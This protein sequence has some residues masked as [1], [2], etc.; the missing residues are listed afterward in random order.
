VTEKIE[1]EEFNKYICADTKEELQ[2]WNEIAGKI[3]L[4]EDE[5]LSHQEIKDAHQYLD[6]F[7]QEIA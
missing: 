5:G 2:K 4:G 6:R 1:D 3:A 7:M